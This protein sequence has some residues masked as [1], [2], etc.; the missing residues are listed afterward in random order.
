MK[1]GMSEQMR[2][3]VVVPVR[4]EEDSIRELLDGLLA[5]T[6]PPDEIVITD[7]G[8][9]DK[10]R[11][12]IREFVS[13]GK[14]VRLIEVEA[15]L[16]GRGRNIA[17]A[18]AMFEWIGFIDAGIRPELNWLQL[19]AARATEDVDVVYGTLEPTVDT[20]FRECAAIA[21]VPP[22]TLTNGVLIRPRSI[23]SSLMRREVWSKA[24]GFPE[25]LR[26]AEDLIFMNRVEASGARTVFEPLAVVHWTIKH[27]FTSTFLRFISYSRN[28]IRAGLWRQWQAAILGRY[29]MLG[30]LALLSLVLGVWWL[31]V[32][33]I[34]W[35]AMLLAR[36]VVSIKRNRN[37]YPASLGRNFK[38]LLVLVPLIGVLD[39]A[40][41]VGT[42]H[43][44]AADSYRK[45]STHLLEA[46]NG[47]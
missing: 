19:L 39:A 17:A 21:Y 2:I 22:Q 27:N 29:F 46:R 16:P 15:A 6:R 3:S 11:D 35:V 36:A 23:A 20:F 18:H 33:V 14:P 9:T 7:G 41:I 10:T 5:Q 8:S 31:A 13:D 47:T 1:E 24:A 42:L 28:N 44:L 26:S 12:I 32:P 45:R 34:L 38:R 4:D 40:A 37:Q 30:L 43:W 25:G